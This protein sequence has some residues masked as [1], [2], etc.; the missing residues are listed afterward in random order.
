MADLQQALEKALFDRLTDQVTLARVFQHVPEN[1]P[2]PVVII[3]DMSVSAAGGKSSRLDRFEFDI[4]SLI[5]S[6]ERKPLNALQ[7]EVRAALDFWQPAAASGVEIGE[8]GFVSGDGYLLP[9]EAVYYGTQRF[10]CFVQ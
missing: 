3:A 5:K 8:I 10:A 6:D 2:P 9:D 1:T 4:V 7:T